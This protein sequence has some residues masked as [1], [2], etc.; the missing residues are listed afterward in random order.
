MS[1]MQKIK[2]R[3]KIIHADR[4]K[5]NEQISTSKDNKF[6]RWAKDNNSSSTISNNSL[7][8]PGS[9]PETEETISTV[10]VIPAPNDDNK[11]MKDSTCNIMSEKNKNNLRHASRRIFQHVCSCHKIRKDPCA[12]LSLSLGGMLCHANLLHFLERLSAT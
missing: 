4:E 1:T 7:K 6:S 9:K 2:T 3:K 12:Y 5:N 11:N 10:N 8:H